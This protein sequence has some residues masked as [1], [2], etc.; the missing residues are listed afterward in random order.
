[1]TPDKITIETSDEKLWKRFADLCAPADAAYG[2]LPQCS[3]GIINEFG[4]LWLVQHWDDDKRRLALGLP[5]FKIVLTKPVL[6]QK[7]A[8]AL[9]R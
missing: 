5:R 9:P 2:A 3:L 7:D 6:I 8:K 4:G 1:M